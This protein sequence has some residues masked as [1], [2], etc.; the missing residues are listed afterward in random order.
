MPYMKSFNDWL[1]NKITTYL[2]TSEGCTVEQSQYT[3]SGIGAIIQDSFGFRY[4]VHV[5]VL[6]RITDN[7]ESKYEPIQKTNDTVSFKAEF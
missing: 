6:G 4:E 5:K 1:L 3:Q 2:A 7:Q